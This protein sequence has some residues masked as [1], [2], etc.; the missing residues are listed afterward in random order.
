LGFFGGVGSGRG[1]L[2]VM[3]MGRETS[4]ARLASEVEEL[5]A[6]ATDPDASSGGDTLR[7]SASAGV[8]TGV[9]AAT[10]DSVVTEEV[11]IGGAT[12][13][14]GVDAGAASVGTST[15]ETGPEVGADGEGSRD[16]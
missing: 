7:A 15:D 11:E 6:V 13:G 14:M 8:D 3:R 4:C 16:A 2:S 1:T 12:A 10:E 5:G 9:G